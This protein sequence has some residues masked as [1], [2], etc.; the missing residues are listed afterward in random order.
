MQDRAREVYD[1]LC[2]LVVVE[3]IPEVSNG[4]G[5]IVTAWSFGGVWATAL[6]ANLESFEVSQT[7]LEKYVR[8]FILLGMCHESSAC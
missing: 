4:G 6:L 5:M 8:R 2:E 1:L 7:A 3:H